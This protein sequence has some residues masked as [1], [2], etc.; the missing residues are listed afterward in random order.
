MLVLDDMLIGKLGNWG[1]GLLENWRT[2]VLENL[3]IGEFTNRKN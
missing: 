3:E 2:S 1:I